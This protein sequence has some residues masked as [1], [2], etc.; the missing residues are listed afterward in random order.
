M[1]NSDAFLL[2]MVTI[3]LAFFIF[4]NKNNIITINEKLDNHH[5]IQAECEEVITYKQFARPQLLCYMGENHNYSSNEQRVIE[6]WKNSNN[7]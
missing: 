1:I 2:I 7:N 6:Q 5:I 4:V 3:V